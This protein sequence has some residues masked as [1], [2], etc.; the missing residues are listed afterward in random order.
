MASPVD[1]KASAVE[2]RVADRF[3]HLGELAAADDDLARRGRFLDADVEIRV[4]S[5]P[6]GIAIRAG[7]VVSV[8]RGPFLLKSSTFTIR[9]EADAWERFLE[10]FPVPGF[11][12]LMAMTKAGMARVEGNLTPFMGNLQYIKDLIA[13]PRG[14]NGSGGRA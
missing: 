1:S 10:P 13:L 4:G 6:L 12:D 3:A 14:K 9:A 8:T 11:H 7:R 5:I 2:A